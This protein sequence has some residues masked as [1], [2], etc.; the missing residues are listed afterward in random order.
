MGKVTE[1]CGVHT[2][3]CGDRD[4]RG[5]AGA[6]GHAHVV[7]YEEIA[8]IPKTKKGGGTLG[9][10][11]DDLRFSGVVLL[12]LGQ[13]FTSSSKCNVI[14]VGS[15][16]CRIGVPV[17]SRHGMHRTSRSAHAFRV[18][19]VQL[20]CHAAEEAFAHLWRDSSAYVRHDLLKNVAGVEWC[21]G[22]GSA[23]H[24][25]ADHLLRVP[26]PL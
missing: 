8:C 11:L 2:F 18:L 19:R 3:V 13:G 7:A 9:E 1:E 25:L 20:R 12:P 16:A 24:S 5:R 17:A 15:A 4:N 10:G 6:D 26:T 22:R 14:C 23:R 21:T